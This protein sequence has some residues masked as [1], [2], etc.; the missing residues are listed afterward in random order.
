MS[1]VHAV[2]YAPPHGVS[3]CEELLILPGRSLRGIRERRKRSRRNKDMLLFE[4]FQHVVLLI[5]YRVSKN[6][7]DREKWC[8]KIALDR[9]T[10]K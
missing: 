7:N 6:T 9:A 2:R 4:A 1:P 5:F 10:I 3:T 8:P